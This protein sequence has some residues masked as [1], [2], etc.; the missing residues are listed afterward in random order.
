MQTQRAVKEKINIILVDP[1]DRKIGTIEKITGHRYAMLHRAFSVVIFRNHKGEREVLLQQRSKK[2]YHG[3]GLWTNACCS[4]PRPNEKISTAA[5]RR[6]K[7]EMGL[8]VKLKE[9]GK[10]HYV[11]PLD[12]GMTENEIDHV[13]VGNY[14]DENIKADR[15]EVEAYKW[16]AVEKLQKDLA[17]KPKHYTPWLK[18][19]L[20]L[21]L[22]PKRQIR[23]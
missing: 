15:N 6:L 17:A 14:T 22:K 1:N 7:D 5:K 10:F 9:V 13:F 12:K 21:A 2:K 3:G 18:Q 20:D 11:A 16:V 19:A 4:H 23:K 8:E